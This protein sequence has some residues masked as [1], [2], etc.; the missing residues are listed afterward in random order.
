[1]SP[2]LH[3]NDYVEQD[4]YRFRDDRYSPA[5]VYD[6]ETDFSPVHS[7]KLPKSLRLPPEAYQLDHMYKNVPKTKSIESKDSSSGKSVHSS[8]EWDRRTY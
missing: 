5:D 4:K 6:T 2:P 8:D 1:M 7:P 3:S